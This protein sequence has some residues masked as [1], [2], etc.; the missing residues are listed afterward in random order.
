MI[1][2]EVYNLL[3]R[4]EYSNP[5]LKYEPRTYN[6]QP[7]HPT[8]PCSQ[9]MAVVGSAYIN[10]N[11][12]YDYRWLRIAMGT[13]ILLLLAASKTLLKGKEVIAVA[14]NEGPALSDLVSFR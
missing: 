5:Y 10:S 3:T 9:P 8:N 4:E 2:F 11:I 14:L 13:D 6:V 1:L 7:P 12:C